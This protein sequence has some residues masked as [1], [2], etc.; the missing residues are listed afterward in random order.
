[1]H[2]DVI[3]IIFLQE[4]TV[5]DIEEVLPV[6]LPILI[7]QLMGNIRELL[8]KI[9]AAD[10]V[11]LLQHSRYG[12]YVRSSRVHSQGGAGMF[13]GPCVGNIEYIPQAGP[14]PGIVHQGNAFGA[15]PHIAPHFLIP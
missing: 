11:A 6:F 2:F 4:G 8:G 1:M 7:C 3:F 14:I 9:I 5:N 12:I 13:T 10:P 15:A